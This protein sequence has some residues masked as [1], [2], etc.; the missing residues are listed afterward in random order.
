M[1]SDRDMVPEELQEEE[2][3]LVLEDGLN[4]GARGIRGSRNS[5]VSGRGEGQF[6]MGPKGGGKYKAKN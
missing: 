5:L 4:S 2:A 3:G 1:P 6:S